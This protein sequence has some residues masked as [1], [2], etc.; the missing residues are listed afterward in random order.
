MTRADKT[1]SRSDH[2][3]TL[4]L[5]LER[6]QRVEAQSSVQEASPGSTTPAVNHSCS[7]ASATLQCQPWKSSGGA[8]TPNSVE[9]PE[10]QSVCRPSTLNATSILSSAMGDVQRLRKK[11]IAGP[12]E[13]VTAE[14]NIAPD[15]AR[16]WVKSSYTP[17]PWDSAMRQIQTRVLI[18]NR[19][20][21]QNESQDLPG[22]K[23]SEAH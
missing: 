8:R 1:R 23:R 2:S 16:S 17:N 21:H 15:T 10:P 14:I 19:L 11:R 22:T 7:P 3:S 6:L 12:K 18:S 13:L 20:L 9:P 5:I 4:A